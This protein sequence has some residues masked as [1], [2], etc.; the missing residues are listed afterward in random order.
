MLAGEEAPDVGGGGA[1]ALHDVEHHAAADAEGDI[2]DGQGARPGVAVQL[3][4]VRAG[5]RQPHVALAQ[6]RGADG[7]PGGGR[8]VDRADPAEVPHAG[9]VP[10][11]VREQGQ[12]GA[13]AHGGREG[14]RVHGRR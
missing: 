6:P 3:P 1:G 14:P 11:G 13:R 9:V 7:V 2:G 4:G 12:R 10:R 8:G 5:A